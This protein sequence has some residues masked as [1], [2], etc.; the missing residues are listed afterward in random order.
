MKLI[1]SRIMGS[2]FLIAVLLLSALNVDWIMVNASE[3][4]NKND[5][6]SES[7]EQETEEQKSRFDVI[8]ADYED[9][10]EPIYY[11]VDFDRNEIVI[12]KIKRRKRG[13]RKVRSTGT[14]E[15][16]GDIN[17]WEKVYHGKY[18]RYQIEDN[19]DS[20]NDYDKQIVVE[21][22]ID[23]VKEATYSTLNSPPDEFKDKP[24]DK[25]LNNVPAGFT[26]GYMFGDFYKFNSYASD[27]GLG[28]TMIWL[29]GSYIT[30]KTMDADVQNKKVKSFW[31]T[32]QD[33]DGHWWI[34]LLDVDYFTT[35]DKYKKLVNHS[36]CIT[37]EY[38]GY[39]GEYKKPV[40][41]VEKIFDRDTG[42]TIY[43]AWF[44]DLHN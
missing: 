41:L 11:M 3:A 27:N 9:R 40:I 20:E 16:I 42:K 34:V 32:L 12:C 38:Q 29:Y 36:L 6:E 15:V 10:S 44:D 35:I 4:T 43:S 13:P 26:S 21:Y 33:P 19:P 24:K 5:T 25:K 31:A 23:G 22:S 28:G 8:Y 17:G 30:L 14:Y 37:G 2:V 7:I 39:S 1:K 18:H